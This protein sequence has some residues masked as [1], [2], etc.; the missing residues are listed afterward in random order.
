MDTQAQLAALLTVLAIPHVYY[1]NLWGNPDRWCKWCTRSGKDPCQA[2]ATA[3]HAIKA[4][5]FSCFAL[6]WYAQHEGAWAVP[7]AWRLLACALLAGLGQALNGG[8]YNAIG[9][10][11]VYYGAA[12][13]KTI[14]WCHGFPY[15][16]TWLKHPQ[17]IGAAASIAGFAFVLDSPA[18]RASGGSVVLGWWLALYAFTSWHEGAGKPRKVS[19][20][21]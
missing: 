16:I 7:E 17:Y 12:F 15:N 21:K 14:P 18:H 4:L 1:F 19:K 13:G 20:G 5:Q 6:W 11:G 8:V 2:M 10:E 9:I 3:A